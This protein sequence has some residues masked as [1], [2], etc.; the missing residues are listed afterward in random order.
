M[1]TDLRTVLGVVG[2]VALVWWMWGRGPTT[3][4]D[5][6]GGQPP[7]VAAPAPLH[8]GESAEPVRV[9]AAAVAEDGDVA[10]GLEVGLLVVDAVTEAPLG[11]SVQVSGAP[12]VVLTGARES[13]VVQARPEGSVSAVVVSSR[14]YWS[15]EFR[16]L[17]GRRD[18]PVKIR[19]QR[20]SQWAIT[21]TDVSGVGMFGVTLE[22][23]STSGGVRTSTPPTDNNGLTL[24]DVPHGAFVV[25]VAAPPG[26]VPVSASPIL[27]GGHLDSSG[28]ATVVL[29]RLQ[30]AAVRFVGDEVL[31]GYLQRGFPTGI[32]A[33]SYLPE[34]QRLEAELRRQWPD[35][36]VAA[37]IPGGG[38]DSVWVRGFARHSGWLARECM[39]REFGPGFEPQAVQLAAGSAPHTGVIQVQVLNAAGAAWS[40]HPFFL[41]VASGNSQDTLSVEIGA[42]GE[43]PVPLGRVMV[44]SL[45]GGIRE[46]VEIR[47]AP[48]QLTESNRFAVV[49]IRAKARLVERSFV[50]S[51]EDAGLLRR[52]SGLV[53][54][55]DEGGPVGQV[56]VADGA[57]A[58]WGPIR[59]LE[60][61][62]IVHAGGRNLQVRAVLP[63]ANVAGPVDVVMR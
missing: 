15:E 38:G 35:A 6:V 23:Q 21:V 28:P 43:L 5:E 17:H 58:F 48:Q 61:R 37:A 54:L 10:R 52:Y 56:P 24:V 9:P 34:A 62:G 1:R 16:V 45:Q 12:G 7:M 39:Y 20:V 42:G 41:Q 31:G 40:G 2:V 59:E 53:Q 14:G 46:W 25:R 50:L 33:A 44:N 51:V 49:T 4:A 3:S 19:M 55:F 47:G 22:L 8:P 57:L 36:L 60:I 30:V 27:P 11:A 26:L 63:G 29:G 13:W 18:G 32:A